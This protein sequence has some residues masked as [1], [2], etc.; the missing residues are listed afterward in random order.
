MFRECNNLTGSRFLRGIVCIGGLKRDIQGSTLDE[1]LV[2]IRQLRKRCRI[3][4][5]I[6]L[7]TASV[8]DRFATTGVI[9]PAL[10]RPL[11]IT[12][13][14]ATGI[15]WKGGCQVELSVRDI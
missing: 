3:G 7:S 9:R 2:F 8:I 10:L 1:L 6:V 4:L 13:P 11:N 14:I 15:R 5:K 12:G